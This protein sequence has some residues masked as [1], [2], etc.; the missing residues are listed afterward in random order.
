MRELILVSILILSSSLRATTLYYGSEK[1]QVTLN[2]GSPT[3]FRFDEEIKTITQASNF[4]IS[5]VDKK[6]PDYRMISI[7]PLKKKASDEV[8]FILSNDAAIALVLKTTNQKASKPGK[9]FFDFKPK[10]HKLDSINKPVGS[11]VSEVELMKAMIRRAKVIGYQIKNLSQKVRTGIEG[12]E[13]YLIQVYS[14]PNFHGYA[15]RVSNTSLNKIYALD[16]KSMTL[17]RPNTAILSQSDQ[18]I[19][20][21]SGPS[22]STILRIVTKPTSI[23]YDITLPVAPIIKQ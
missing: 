7:K 4:Q 18:K 21:G 12:I 6:N 13:A 10:S 19:L 11:Q 14:G 5:P 15:F 3:I 20:Y 23:S 8:T 1:E 17:G 2:F 22:R 16:L 9:S